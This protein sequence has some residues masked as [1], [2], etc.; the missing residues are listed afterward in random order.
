MSAIV[1]RTFRSPYD[2]EFLVINMTGV[3]GDAGH[4]GMTACNY[5]L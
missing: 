2:I 3:N 1:R 5:V 4:I